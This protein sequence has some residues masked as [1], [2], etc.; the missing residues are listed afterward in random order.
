MVNSWDFYEK[1]WISGTGRTAAWAANERP[2]ET[3]QPQFLAEPPAGGACR[4]A[5]CDVTSA[6]NTRTMRATW[7]P[8]W[9]CGN[10]A[11][12][13]AAGTALG[14]LALAAVL[15]SMTFDWLLRRVASGLHLNRFYL[16][17]MRLPAVAEAEL[18]E[19][20]GFAAAAMLGGRAGGLPAEATE[21]LRKIS[22]GRNEVSAARVESIVAKGYRLGP[23]DLRRMLDPD[24][25]DRKG[26]WRYFAAVPQA[27]QVASES[28]R[29]LEAA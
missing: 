2:L 9:P 20:A 15:N 21:E 4:L 17:T 19:L 3:C 23:S 24:A 25:A 10:T 6:T 12:V 8:P 11:P 13:L 28:V 16:E 7:V 18:S 1:S 26:L 29:L 5:I 22:S 27:E 14:A